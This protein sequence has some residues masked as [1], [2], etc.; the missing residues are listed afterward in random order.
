MNKTMKRIL[1]ATLVL[2]LVATL[3]PLAAASTSKAISP[4][5]YRVLPM[6]GKELATNI[7]EEK[8]SESFR[9]TLT[10]PAK[11]T[12]KV[13]TDLSEGAT[14]A[15]TK[16]R[17]F[18]AVDG[19]E[20]IKNGENRSILKYLSKGE[21]FVTVSR[22]GVDEGGKIKVSA[23]ATNLSN[24]NDRENN[25]ANADATDF[26]ELTAATFKGSFLFDDK[27]DCYK[28]T[29]QE[30]SKLEV[31]VKALTD[32]G[33]KIT[34][35]VGQLDPSGDLPDDT[36]E[37]VC[38]KGSENRDEAFFSQTRQPG[39]YYI[40]VSSNIGAGEYEFTSSNITAPIQKLVT[41]K[42]VTVK[43]GKKVNLIKAIKPAGAEDVIRIS[44]ADDSKVEVLNY[45]KATI[46]GLKVGKTK[47]TISI[48]NGKRYVCNVTVK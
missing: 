32:N 14:F 18:T 3:L 16:G 7:T 15:L 22:I 6:N 17:E 34:L 45:K 24:T 31:Q 38:S 36:W 13:S 10:K 1:S 30:T 5:D 44:V 42:N 27:R 9:F 35:Q 19:I 4:D 28:I 21:Y 41:K 23:K 37:M 48:P 8:I 47:V 39:T 40:V 43:V 20:K 26:S 11:V 12:F 33:G 29:L 25:D 2:M 46:Q